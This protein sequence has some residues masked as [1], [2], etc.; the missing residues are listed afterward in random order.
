MIPFSSAPLFGT[1]VPMASAEPTGSATPVTGFTATRL[2]AEQPGARFRKS[3]PGSRGMVV[4]LSEVDRASRSDPSGGLGAALLLLEAVLRV[5]PK[6]PRVCPPQLR[7]AD[8]DVVGP[9]P[10]EKPVI[11]RVRR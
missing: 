5:D 11:Q 4:A 9:L 2:A 8:R 1:M 7:E 3:D 6:L 10:A